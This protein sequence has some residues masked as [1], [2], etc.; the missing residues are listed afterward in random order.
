[1]SQGEAIKV[2]RDGNIN[3]MPHEGKDIIHAFVLGEH[4]SSIQ[5]KMTSRKAKWNI[6]K[7]AD[8]MCK[9]KMHTLVPDV[10]HIEKNTFHD[11]VFTYRP[12]IGGLR[13]GLEGIDVW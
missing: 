3:N 9:R 8:L 12:H 10:M 13:Q 11:S 1:M 4:V 5:G 7:D 6:G 2:V